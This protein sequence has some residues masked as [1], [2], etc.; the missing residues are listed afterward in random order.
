MRIACI[1]PEIFNDRHKCYS[2]IERLLK[3]LIQQF[4]NCD[5][6]CLPERWVP[7]F[8]DF[9]ENIQEER[10]ED[11]SFIKDLAKDY[12]IN[13]ISGAIWENRSSI[14]KPMITSYFFSEKGE[15]I[16]RQEKIHLY[17]YEKKIFEPGKILNLF[18]LNNSFFSILICFD[19]AF[20]ETPRLAVENGADI[21]FS[22]TQIKENGKKN[23]RIYLQARSLENRVPIVACNTVG[24]L[25]SGKFLGESKI[26]SFEKD[27]ISPSK[28]KLVEAPKDSGFIYDDVD[29]TFPRDIRKIRL[30]E[31]VEKKS[32]KVKIINN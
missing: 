19:I 11:Y 14:N 5:I 25:P 31:H 27:F 28:L 29:L 13:I 17:S 8:K 10:G 20:F 23:W 12:N 26:I 30:K 6:L 7:L 2:E 18:K 15:E 24:T 21:L 32:I 1:Q 3:L 4:D 16:G 9:S 22:P